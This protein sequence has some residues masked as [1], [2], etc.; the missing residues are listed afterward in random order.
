MIFGEKLLYMILKGQATKGKINRASRNKNVLCFKGCH[1]ESEETSHRMGENICKI[2][3]WIRNLS[4]YINNDS[5]MK[6]KITQFKIWQRR[7]P[8]WLSGY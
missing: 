7:F 1:Q 6:G 2:I 8:L 3:F 4:E 5:T